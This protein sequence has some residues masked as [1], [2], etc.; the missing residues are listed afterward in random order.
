MKVGEVLLHGKFED[1]LAYY[2]KKPLA[3]SSAGNLR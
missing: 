3:A 2:R 1:E